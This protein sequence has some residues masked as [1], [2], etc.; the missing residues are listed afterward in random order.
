[1]EHFLKVYNLAIVEFEK[2]IKTGCLS[3]K[4]KGKQ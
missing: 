3:K 2:K 4:L 1:M